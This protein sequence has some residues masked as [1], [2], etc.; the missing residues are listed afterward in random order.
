[1]SSLLIKKL[2]VWVFGTFDIY[3]RYIGHAFMILCISPNNI[4]YFDELRFVV[5]CKA[6]QSQAINPESKLI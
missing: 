1:M 2:I 4:Y 3:Y 6:L 5:Q